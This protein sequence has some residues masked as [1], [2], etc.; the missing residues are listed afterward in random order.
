LTCGLCLS[1]LTST[2]KIQ[3]EGTH[4]RGETM[5]HLAKIGHQSKYASDGFAAKLGPDGKHHWSKR[6][7]TDGGTSVYL[8]L[9][10]DQGLVLTGLFS[11]GHLGPEVPLNLG[12]GPAPADEGTYIARFDLDGKHLW[13][14]TFNS[15]LYVQGM[16][17]DDDD[18]LA[19][20]GTFTD[21]T[22]DLGG[23]P[24]VRTPRTE[25]CDGATMPE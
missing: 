15:N 18:S 13:S 11:P 5:K 12:G 6:F 16:V 7:G 8:Q 20:A 4:E 14:R 3:H 1:T 23:G 25:D 21:E 24:L 10:D 2:L 9:L 22:V 17:S 19:I